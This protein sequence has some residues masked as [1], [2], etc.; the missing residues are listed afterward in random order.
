MT[1]LDAAKV[2]ITASIPDSYRFTNIRLKVGITDPF[3]NPY[4]Y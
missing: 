2:S 3:F 4:S 1:K